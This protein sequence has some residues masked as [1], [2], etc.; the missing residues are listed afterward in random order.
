[1][2]LGIITQWVKLILT[3]QIM[4]SLGLQFARK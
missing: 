3:N 1:L 2:F 4:V